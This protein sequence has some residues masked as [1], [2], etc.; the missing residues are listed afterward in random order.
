[1]IIHEAKDT[2]QRKQCVW[3]EGLKKEGGKNIG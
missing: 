1:M 3:E 2:R